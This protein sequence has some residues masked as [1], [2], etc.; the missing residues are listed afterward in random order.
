[1]LRFVI[2]AIVVIILII[3]LVRLF[4][5]QMVFFPS[6]YPAGFRQLQNAGLDLKDVW[7]AAADG[8]KLHGWFVPHA[9]PQAALLMCHGNAGNVSDRYEWLEMLHAQ[10]PANLFIFDYRGFGR[11]EGAPTEEGCYLDAVAALQW[12]AAQK[13]ELPIVVHG[14]SLGSA[15]AVELAHRLSDRAP[16]GLILE[17]GFT[18]ATDMGKL[19]FGPIPLYW[20]TSMKWASDKKIGAITI[21]KLFL[22]GE[23]DSI[24]PLRL[25][26]KLFDAA[27]PPKEFAVLA[28]ANHNDTFVAGGDEYY[29]VIRDFV[30]RCVSRGGLAK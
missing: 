5:R 6:K 24:I 27:A 23:H 2:I 28:R 22:H 25:G 8:V 4:E 16:A 15:V 3:L 9:Q 21:P 26:Q 12:L 7:F 17:S 14:H 1:M 18:N 29:R 20:L 10:V 30:R 19:M 11:S 13:P